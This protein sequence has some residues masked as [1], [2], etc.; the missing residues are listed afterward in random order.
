VGGWV[1]F[2]L[3]VVMFVCFTHDLAGRA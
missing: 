1:C 3:S 2:L